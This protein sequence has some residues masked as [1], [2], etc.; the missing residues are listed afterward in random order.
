LFGFAVYSSKSDLRTIITMKKAISPDYQNIDDGSLFGTNA[1]DFDKW[2]SQQL[3]DF[4]SSAGLM[5]YKKMVLDHKITGKFAHL[6]TDE[7]LR[8]MGMIVVGDRLR[9]KQLMMTMG[10]KA[11]FCNTTKA[12]WSGEEQKYYSDA[13]RYCCTCVGLVP[14]GK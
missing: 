5:A 4:L 10:R 2:D 13:E 6:L 12:I 8:D 14:D 1:E 11:R 9:F 7:D 3:A